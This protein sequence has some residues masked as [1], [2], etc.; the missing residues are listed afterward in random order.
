MSPKYSEIE[1]FKIKIFLICFQDTEY[2]DIYLGIEK[3]T[4]VAKRA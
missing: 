3:M 2:P 4:V 1:Y